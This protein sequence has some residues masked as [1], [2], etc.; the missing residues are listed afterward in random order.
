MTEL[1]L[2]R[3]WTMRL[4]FALLVCVILF[5]HLL[6]L[7]TTPQRWVGPDL[8][9]AFAFAW[10]SR[11]PEYVPALALAGLFLLADLLMQRP[12]GLW[13][14]LALLAC[15]H[16]KARA[17]G[18]RDANFAAEWLSVCILIAAI[19][20][21]YRVVLMVT[22]VDL[23]QFSLTLF[24]TLMT[25]LFYPVIVPVTHGIMRVRKATPGDLEPSGSRS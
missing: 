1:P 17:R 25:M 8:L 18:L 9:L 16:L 3:L 2:T 20:M 6:P 21:G 12:P 22:A 24:E 23:P 7:Q 13:A 14:M 15:E 11:R 19:A 10:S 4:G 5:F